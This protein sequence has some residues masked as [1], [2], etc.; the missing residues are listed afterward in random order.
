MVIII[1]ISSGGDFTE[2]E[3]GNDSAPSTAGELRAALSHRDVTNVLLVCGGRVLA[4]GDS[5]DGLDAQIF[6][7]QQPSSEA[8]EAARARRAGALNVSVRCVRGGLTFRLNNLQPT[9]TVAEVKTLIFARLATRP[10]DA[11]RLIFVGK[12][13]DDARDL[14]SI[15]VMDGATLHLAERSVRTKIAAAL[16]A[17]KEGCGADGTAHRLALKTLSAIVRNVQK[18]PDE[19]KYRKLRAGNAAFKRKFGGLPGSD[20]VLFAVGFKATMRDAQRHWIL[21]DTVTASD[22]DSVAAVL[23]AEL[24]SYAPVAAPVAAAAAAPRWAPPPQRGFTSAPPAAPFGGGGGGGGGFAA[25]AQ[26]MQA[27]PQLMAMA[28]Q[29]RQNPEMMALATQLGQTMA[30]SGGGANDFGGAGTQ[31]FLGQ[32]AGNPQLMAMANNPQ[33]RAMAE[34]FAAGGGAGGGA[35]G[36]VSGFGAP[37]GR[38]APAAPAAPSASAAAA[39]AAEEERLIAEA[40]EASMREVAESSSKKEKDGDKKK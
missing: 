1:S 10:I 22:L 38:P 32:L 31:N 37:A 28:N 40:I 36:G 2:L 3:I 6:A 12:E 4:D 7:T 30:A 9:T 16:H 20:R 39:T 33:I 13:I 35:R 27:N 15:G 21:P 29:M 14:G 23:A 24:A 8:L 26:Q 18:K 25:M 5:L 17:L 11:Q 19:A 34:Q